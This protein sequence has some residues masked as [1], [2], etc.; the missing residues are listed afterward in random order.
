[1]MSIFWARC[2]RR[3]RSRPCSVAPRRSVPVVNDRGRGARGGL[4]VGRDFNCIEPAVRVRVLDRG[5]IPVGLR[6][7][8][9]LAGVLGRPG[10]DL[11][12]RER[13]IACRRE[14]A[15]G[16]LR[17]G[18]DVEDRPR[19]A[20]LG[21]EEQLQIDRRS[22][23]AGPAEVRAESL[24]V[25]FQPVGIDRAESDDSGRR[26]AHDALQVGFG[27]GQLPLERD[28]VEREVGDVGGSV[29]G[30]GGRG[31]GRD[32]QRGRDDHGERAQARD[33]TKTH[34][35]ESLRF[36]GGSRRRVGRE[37]SAGCYARSQAGPAGRRATLAKGLQ[38][39]NGAGVGRGGK[40]A[41]C[42]G[43]KAAYL[44]AP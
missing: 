28:R 6:E 14:A 4:D 27:H 25:A 24:R 31:G 33:H 40:A 9:G 11:G 23:V 29:L 38:P 43:A 35:P 22:P 42:G 1:M 15:H 13:L 26:R 18:V 20:L 44:C 2:L 19:G 12:L 30:P 36:G 3:G 17:P 10:E 7:V 5:A 8:E 41:L 16:A 32:R 39:V 34:R 21:I 37:P